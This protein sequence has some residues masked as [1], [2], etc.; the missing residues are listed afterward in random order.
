M[1][2]LPTSDFVG[3]VRNQVLVRDNRP[4][5]CAPHIAVVLVTGLLCACPSISNMHTARPL[6][7]DEVEKIAS[8]GLNRLDDASTGDVDYLPQFDVMV[9]KGFGERYDAGIRGNTSALIQAD[10]NFALIQT[11]HFALSIDPI[12]AVLPAPDGFATYFWLPLFADVYTSEDLTV[13]IS[14]RWG[15]FNI[16][17]NGDDDFFNIDQSTSLYGFGIGVRYESADGKIW[18]PELSYLVPEDDEFEDDNVLTFSMG[19]VF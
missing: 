2:F 7:V 1:D 4:K 13:T 19:F 11:D 15:R 12:V 8:I 18:M 14:G 17:G 5:N 10:V 3:L 6:L 16:D 9:R